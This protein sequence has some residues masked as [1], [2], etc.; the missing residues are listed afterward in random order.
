MT[1]IPATWGVETRRVTVWGHRGQYISKT[2]ILTNKLG[3]V[4]YAWHPNC[5]EGI[6][7][8][9]VVQAGSHKKCETLLE[10]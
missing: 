7:R 10:K 3:M 1:V 4:A 8:K 9:I 5:I 6:N 2:P